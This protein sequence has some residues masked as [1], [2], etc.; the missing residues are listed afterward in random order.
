MSENIQGIFEIKKSWFKVVNSCV[1]TIHDTYENKTEVCFDE[2]DSVKNKQSL[3]KDKVL[4]YLKSNDVGEITR[5]ELCWLFNGEIPLSAI[6]RALVELEKLGYIE[7]IG[8][9]RNRTFKLVEAA[10]P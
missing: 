2:Y 4:E 10:L 8:N 9:T 1:F 7:G 3:A 6:K 5:K